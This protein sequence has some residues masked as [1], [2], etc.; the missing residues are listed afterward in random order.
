MLDSGRLPAAT[1]FAWLPARLQL[2][3][4]WV[5]AAKSSISLFSTTPVPGTVK[6]APNGRFT[7]RVAATALPWAS[8]TAKWVVWS[9]SRQAGASG[10]AELGVARRGSMP[11]ARRFR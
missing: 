4:P 2:L 11:A 7:E 1:A 9:P 8:I 3:A 10:S 6:A 5:S